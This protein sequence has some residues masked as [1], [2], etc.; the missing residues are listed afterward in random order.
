MI[1]LIIWLIGG[2]FYN[3]AFVVFNQHLIYP[4][5]PGFIRIPY[6]F[7]GLQVTQYLHT[8]CLSSVGWLSCEYLTRCQNNWAFMIRDRIDQGG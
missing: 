5:Q 4:P 8:L 3:E 1:A 6:N 7:T 2:C